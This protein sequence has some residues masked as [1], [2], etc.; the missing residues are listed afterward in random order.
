M[1]FD[2]VIGQSDIKERLL[3][4]VHENRVPHAMLFCGPNGCGKM[5][6]ATAF[7]CHLLGNGPMLKKLQH[8]DLHFTYPT[9]KLPSMGEHQPV[10]SDFATEWNDMILR[11]PYF[12]MD[13]W[14]TAMGANNQQ[15]IITGAESDELSRILSLKSS[16][17][18][19]K[20]SIIWLP[21]RMNQTSANKLLKLLEEPPQQTV[22]I[23]VSE[24]P[25]Q[26]L[27]TIRSRTQRIDIRR[28]ATEDIQQALITQRGLEEEDARRVARLANGNWLNA[29][30]TLDAANEERQFLDFFIMLMR[31]AYTRNVKE[32]KKWSESMAAQ[33]RE[34]QKRM[35]TY[36]SQQVRENF[37]RNF[38]I[39]ELNYM[40]QEEED[41]SKKFSRFINE[42]NV[43]EI[44]ELMAK[45]IRDIGQNANSKVVFFDLA[46][47]MIILL[48]KK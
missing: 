22:F 38:G 5:A 12:S 41:F 34:K 28:I 16:Q 26:L 4:M 32:L 11:S 1:T 13:Q 23:M 18:G 36:F 21:E 43:I 17:G 31:L 9:I 20:V 27:D 10:S 33:G 6:L 35:L 39:P 8:P 29:I 7:G 46:L 3:Q 40:T 42:A 45:A 25:E 2:E 24:A 47:Q 44:S 48:I 30:N 37:I 14:M 15:A 19:Y